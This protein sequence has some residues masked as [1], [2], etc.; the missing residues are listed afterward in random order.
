MV[1]VK[2]TANLQKYFPKQELEVEAGNLRDLLRKMDD[3]QSGFSHYVIDEQNRIRKHV[4]VFINGRLIID[5]NRLDHSFDKG[6]TIHIM[7]AL[8]GG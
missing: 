3:I 8:S 5:K 6:S 2:L 1:Q 7:Q 4:N